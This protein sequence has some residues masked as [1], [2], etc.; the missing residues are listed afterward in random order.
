MSIAQRI[1]ILILVPLVAILGL[2]GLIVGHR[3]STLS[4]MD[5][6]TRGGAIIQSLNDLVAALQSE[7]GRTAV[8]LGAKGAQGS[9]EL[10]VQR[11]ATDDRSKTFTLSVDDRLTTSFSGDLVA[12]IRAATA[13]LGQLAKLRGGVSGRAVDV[14]GTTGH[15]SEIIE[16][17]LG[18]SLAIVHD[19]DQPGVKNYALALN[20]VQAAKER[21]G[22]S[23]ATGGSAL[24]GG[25]LTEDQLYRLVALA[26]EEEEFT[27]L[28]AIYGPPAV[29]DEYAKK[30][31]L[32]EAEQIDSLR[33]L[34]L[35]TPAGQQVASVTADQWFKAATVRV[36]LLNN[37]QNQILSAVLTEV[38]REQSGAV[39]ELVTTGS[40]VLAVVGAL[41]VLGFFI[42]RS[43]STP[44]VAVAKAMAT[45]ASDSL[46]REA[47]TKA[48]TGLDANVTALREKLYAYGKPRRENDK[49]YFGEYLANG[50]NDIVDQVQQRFGGTATIFL[51]GV[52]VA[53]NVLKEDGSRAVGTTL[54]Q[55]PAYESA[56][57]HAKMYKGEAR[58]FGKRYVS[59]YE[60]IIDGAAVIGILYVGVPLEEASLGGTLAPRMRNEVQQM[61]ATLAILEKATK[62]K[63]ETEREALEQR[64]Q[65]T[66]RARQATALSQSVASEQQV[67]VAA[68][69]A[70]LESLANTDL[71]HAIEIQF[72][73]Q[74]QNLKTNFA[75]AVKI[76]RDTVTAI[77]AQTAT[78]FS[79][80]GDISEAVDDLSKRT[81]QQAASLEQTAAALDE[82]T[83]NVR[84]T[85]DGAGHGREVAATTKS[86]A[87][88]SGEVVRRAVTAMGAIQ[89]SSQ[90]IGQIIGVIDEIAFQTNLLALNAGVEA[91]RAGD[92]GRGFAVVASEVRALAQRSAN[93][94]KEIKQLISTSSRQVDE[95]VQ[96]VDETGSALERILL[97]VAEIS[98]IMS[99]IATATKE[100]STGLAE[101][102]T[103][104][105]QMDQVTQQNA[106]MVEQ[107]AAAS[108][109]LREETE[110]LT[111]LIG[112]FQTERGSSATP[113]KELSAPRLQKPVLRAG[114]A[115]AE[116][117]VRRSA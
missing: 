19:T 9:D 66:D 26:A 50:A 90:K 112:R 72:P 52:R 113:T 106:A 44:I 86:D 83:A 93:A 33:R 114:A 5:Q 46:R 1:L 78:I 34:V 77:G 109:S 13:S 15:Y 24:S 108:Q 38:A 67:V 64:Y 61:Q 21:A 14:A 71:T 70:A 28:F 23:R 101:V 76:L 92:A 30:R 110:E 12:S 7:R 48:Q 42:M 74:F 63:D 105:N 97:Q 25:A 43:I 98:S 10:S 35:A 11:Q 100:Q 6:L 81:E 31:K 32:D 58:I 84:H 49:L 40:L 104:V 22:L 65:A 99:D 16:S 18:V 80:T 2:S 88:R 47:E 37:V 56:L 17:L 3:I 29:R 51:G 55:G 54:A 87:E 27:R 115:K 75:E 103:A 91:A 79:V 89:Q 57:E 102:N 39:G 8:F 94:A 117:A 59:L 95:G 20:F 62:A 41:S 85:A 73:A 111:Q 69:S 116:T 36:E 53:T 82:I 96:L 60:P 4:K 45:L 107:S 68:L